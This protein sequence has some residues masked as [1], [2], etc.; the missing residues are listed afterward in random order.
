MIR[1]SYMKHV[2]CSYSVKSRGW[3]ILYF[4]IFQFPIIHS[5]ICPPK[6]GINYCCKILVG[7]LHVINSISEQWLMQNVG[8]DRVNY[9]ELEK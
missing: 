1:I 5:K 8:A 7:S 2:F 4:R 3:R 9:G 6:K